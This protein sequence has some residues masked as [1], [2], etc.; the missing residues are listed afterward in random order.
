MRRTTSRSSARGERQ[1]VLE[2][3]RQELAVVRELTVDQP[4]GQRDAADPEDDLVGAH[5]DAD[6]L[7]A[8]RRGDARPSSSQ[9]PGRARSPR[10]SPSSG[11]SSVVSLTLSR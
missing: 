6:R 10:S 3:L 11:A 1:L 7:G 9:R 2:R 8:V 4:R 5:A